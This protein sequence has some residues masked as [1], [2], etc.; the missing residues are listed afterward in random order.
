MST[1]HDAGTDRIEK[2]SL[3]GFDKVP[4]AYRAP[5]FRSNDKGWGAR[6]KTLERHVTANPTT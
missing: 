4:S 2:K 3:P 5:A 6:M 1:A